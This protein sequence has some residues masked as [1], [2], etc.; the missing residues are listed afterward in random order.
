MHESIAILNVPVDSAAPVGSA[1]AE[2]LPAVADV[3]V[4]AAVAGVPGIVGIVAV[5]SFPT[6][7]IFPELAG[8]PGVVSSQVHLCCCVYS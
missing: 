2:V 8:I 7:E 3:Q 6:F 1:A 5:A 4:H